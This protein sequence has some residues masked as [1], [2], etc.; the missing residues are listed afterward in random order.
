MATIKLKT[1]TALSVAQVREAIGRWMTVDT[2]HYLRLIDGFG[3]V[4]IDPNLK[5]KVNAGRFAEQLLEKNLSDGKVG[6]E[7]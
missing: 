5:I 2:G 1:T 6:E 4:L 7:A 3:N